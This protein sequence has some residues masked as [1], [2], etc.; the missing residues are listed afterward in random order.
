M[1]ISIHSTGTQIQGCHFSVT[2]LVRIC[3]ATL[4]MFMDSCILP[5]NIL[6]L[7]KRDDTPCMDTHIFTVVTTVTVHLDPICTKE[8]CGVATRSSIQSRAKCVHSQRSSDAVSK[9]DGQD[10]LTPVAAVTMACLWECHSLVTRLFQLCS[11][12]ICEA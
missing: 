10:F 1:Y 12:D 4:T 7:H 8:G 3:P 9:N 5:I 2:C 6:M 11:Q